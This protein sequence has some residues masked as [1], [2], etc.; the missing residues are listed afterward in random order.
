[1]GGLGSVACEG[2]LVGSSCVCVLVEGPGSQLSGGQCSVMG[3]YDF[4]Q[5]VFQN[6]MLCSHFSGGSVLELDFLGWILVLV[7]VWRVLMDSH[8]FMFPGVRSSVIVQSSGAELLVSRSQ[9]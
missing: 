9:S 3:L 2:F 1:M 7:C 5:P 8:L 6:L 4:G